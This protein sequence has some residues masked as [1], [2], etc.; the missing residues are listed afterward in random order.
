MTR[1]HWTFMDTFIRN[2][3]CNSRMS[4]QTTV[5]LIKY[6]EIDTLIHAIV[7]TSREPSYS[8]CPTLFLLLLITLRK[9]NLFLMAV[10]PATNRT[11]IGAVHWLLRLYQFV[12][13]QFVQNDVRSWKKYITLFF[14]LW[15]LPLFTF[16]T[17]L[18]SVI[19]NWGQS[20][21]N[22]EWILFYMQLNI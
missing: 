2:T 20:C 6:F 12:Q 11:L 21:I 22:P 17:C 16:L 8:F 19:V 18:I 15:P 10:A 3:Y 7:S 13:N 5:L 9:K 4:T 1:H 14:L